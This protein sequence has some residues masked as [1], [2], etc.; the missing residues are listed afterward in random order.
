[1]VR[2]ALT[3][4][5]QIQNIIGLVFSP[6]GLENPGKTQR[7]GA[8][9]YP[10]SFLRWPDCG[11]GDHSDHSFNKCPSQTSYKALEYVENPLLT[12]RTVIQSLR[13]PEL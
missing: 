11:A 8:C 9:R 3:F 1:M 2:I 10:S 5:A 7:L 13:L 12:R 6:V 4:Q